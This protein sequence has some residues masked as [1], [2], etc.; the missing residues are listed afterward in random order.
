[1]AHFKIH[2]V[3]RFAQKYYISNVFVA[4]FIENKNP[5][6]NITLKGC[7]TTVNYDFYLK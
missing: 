2:L 7:F 3:F 5:S 4:H 1:M 6:K